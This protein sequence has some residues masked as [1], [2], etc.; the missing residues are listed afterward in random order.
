MGQGVVRHYPKLRGVIHERPLN[1]LASMLTLS[2]K[3][4][5]VDEDQK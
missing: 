3:V 1:P 5:S 4:N 2:L